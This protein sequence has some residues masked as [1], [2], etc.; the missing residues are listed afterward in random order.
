MISTGALFFPVHMGVRHRRT[1]TR[2][3]RGAPC[4]LATFHSAE[5]GR[6]AQCGKETGP[7]GPR[8]FNQESGGVRD[9]RASGPSRR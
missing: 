8:F 2:E 5:E 4:E 1:M 9:A 7:G 3:K 6:I